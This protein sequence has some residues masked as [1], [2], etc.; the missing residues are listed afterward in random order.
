V[1]HVGPGEVGVHVGRD[2][3]ALG[4]GGRD[5]L[6]HLGHPAPVL[7]AGDLQVPDLH[8]EAG[9]ASDVDRLVE[10][11]EHLVTLVPHVRG[12]EAAELR[13]RTGEEHQ[14]VGGL[15]ARGRVA[16]RG[17]DTEGT[18]AHRLL[19]LDLHPEELLGGGRLGPLSHHD[20]AY[21]A[22]GDE[23]A[24]VD[25][26]ASGAEPLPVAVEVPPVDL[27]L[28]EREPAHDAAEDLVA[29]RGHRSELAGEL[30][31]DALADLRL[32][33]G[34][35]QHRQL[36][37]AEQVDEPRGDHVV[38]GIDAE[39]GRSVAQVAHPDDAVSLDAHVGPEPGAARAV[40]DPSTLDDQVQLL[41]CGGRQ[42]CNQLQGEHGSR[43]LARRPV[44]A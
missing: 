33:A 3:E 14:L 34:I 26:R 17:G 36:A 44:P 29:D 1:E 41:G 11:L 32:G 8:R 40:D 2:V 18:L 7:L 43:I 23:R 15:V 42:E 20:R 24:D 9:T 31:G 35:D 22:G 16:E 28:V 25:G 21:L 12:V 30:G 37:L 38:V 4:A 5:P 10:G 6:E 27:D 13:R 39:L 19:D